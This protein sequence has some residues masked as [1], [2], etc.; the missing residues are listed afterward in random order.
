LGATN[1]LGNIHFGPEQVIGERREMLR[2]NA[3][4]FATPK[5]ASR[6]DYSSPT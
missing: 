1:R 4:F 5:A 2:A 6:D 3:I